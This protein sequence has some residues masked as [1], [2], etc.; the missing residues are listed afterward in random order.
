MATKKGKT[1]TAEKRSLHDWIHSSSSICTLM[2]LTTFLIIIAI[3]FCVCTPRKY[4]LRVGSISHVTVDA[5]KDIVDEVTTEE[6]RN[7]AAETVEPTYRFQQGVKEEVLTSLENA[8][9]ELRTIQQYGL[10]LR[11][12]GEQ[13]NRPNRPFMNPVWKRA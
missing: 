13:S 9:Q 3:F 11:P 12:E 2:I 7:A 4:D 8:F 5:T 6:K 10:T 1:E